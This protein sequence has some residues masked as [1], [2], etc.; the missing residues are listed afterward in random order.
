MTMKITPLPTYW[1]AEEAHTVIAFLE[2]LRDQLWE[3]YGDTVVD[4]FANQQQIKRGL[5][6]RSSLSLTTIS[7]SNFHPGQT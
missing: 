4:M 5:R 2:V 1:T 6:L 3:I 7:N